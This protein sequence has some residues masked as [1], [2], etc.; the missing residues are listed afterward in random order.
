MRNA[1]GTRGAMVIPLARA[2]DFARPTLHD[3]ALFADLA[4]TMRL[5]PGQMALIARAA[6]RAGLAGRSA[7][8]AA[9]A[10]AIAENRDARAA[11][12]ALFAQLAQ[13]GGA[14]APDTAAAAANPKGF[15]DAEADALGRAAAALGLACT[16]LL[17]AA[18]RLAPAAAATVRLAAMPQRLR[19]F[20]AS[21]SD[22]AALLPAAV[23]EEAGFVAAAA[24]ATADL[25]EATLAPLLAAFRDG[26]AAVAAN[27][28]DPTWPEPARDRALWI[29][30][31]WA[32][33]LA[34]WD[35][36][37]G[38]G[39]AAETRAWR[40]IAAGVPPLPAE[41]APTEAAREAV[42]RTWRPLAPAPTGS[43]DQAILE[44]LRV[45]VP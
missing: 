29:L 39:Q 31:G 26:A 43:N 12:A 27:A 24:A 5:A 32:A 14:A 36:A 15:A 19:L 17:A 2:A 20:A 10:A 18:T 30:D 8:A 38:Q 3:R 28:A 6:A 1:S 11:R 25:A 21:A 9:D 34:R 35:E 37:E 40:A 42:R 33:L 4:A 45:A 23:A 44:R 13:R 16:D 41:A 7:L 22:A